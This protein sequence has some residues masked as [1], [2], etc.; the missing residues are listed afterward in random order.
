MWVS[1]VVCN[2]FALFYHFTVLALHLLSFNT[3]LLEKR[4]CAIETYW[5]MNIFHF[6]RCNVFDC[7][8]ITPEP[9]A[10]FAICI[11][12]GLLINW[13][14][15]ACIQKPTVTDEAEAGDV[16]RVVASS[17]CHWVRVSVNQYQFV[18]VK[19]NPEFLSIEDCK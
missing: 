18:K 16:L 9:L 19:A 13:Y 12:E 6:F 11:K 5:R 3:K 1:S 7:I 15:G 10:S 2:F 8:T 4:L 17:T 14:N